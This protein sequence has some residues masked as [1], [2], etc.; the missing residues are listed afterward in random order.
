[1]LSLPPNHIK[2]ELVRRGL[3]P[4]AVGE[5]LGVSREYV[6]MTIHGKRTAARVR[7]A[8]ANAIE[9][10]YADVWGVADPDQSEPDGHQEEIA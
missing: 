10:P 1:M 5:S 2:A 9:M 3:T 7:R 6:S 8:I 4:G